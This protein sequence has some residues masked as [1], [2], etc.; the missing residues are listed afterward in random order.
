MPF[1]FSGR[2]VCI[3]VY[4]LFVTAGKMVIAASGSADIPGICSASTSRIFQTNISLTGHLLVL[5]EQ[6]WSKIM[7]VEVM[8]LCL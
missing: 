7:P 2:N 6:P 3:Y 5:Q 4:A 8:L 1:G